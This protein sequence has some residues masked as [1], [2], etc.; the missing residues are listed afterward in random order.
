M[1]NEKTSLGPIIGIIIVIIIV[2][3]GGIY[4]WGTKEEKTNETVIS[5]DVAGVAAS[6][7][8]DNLLKETENSYVD[9]LTSELTDINTELKTIK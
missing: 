4:F 8:V 5:N 3:L 7:S 6:D 2:I 1:E 9:D